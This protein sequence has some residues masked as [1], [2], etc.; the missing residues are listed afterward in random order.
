MRQKVI[1]LIT[2]IICGIILGFGPMV[3][4]INLFHHM[5]NWAIIGGLIGLAIPITT[6]KTII[7]ET[8]L[9]KLVVDVL[10]TRSLCAK[11]GIQYNNPKTEDFKK[12]REYLLTKYEVKYEDNNPE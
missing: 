4:P 9:E 1:G 10:Y 8:E 5:F 7:N 6:Q 12:A 3:Y 11:L 2:G